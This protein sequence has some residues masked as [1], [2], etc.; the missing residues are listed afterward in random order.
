MVWVCSWLDVS[1]ERNGWGRQVDSFIARDDADALSLVF[2]RAP[3]I[4]EVGASATVLLSLRGEPVLV[5]QDNVTGATFHPELTAERH[6]HRAVFG[7]AA[8]S[9]RA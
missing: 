5:R 7:V 9:D 8:S 6:I 1:V 4:V 3:R 2:I